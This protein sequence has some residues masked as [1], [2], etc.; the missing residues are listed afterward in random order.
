MK[1]LGL[2]LVLMLLAISA[3]ACKPQGDQG[4][5]QSGP[6][7]WVDAPLPGNVAL[8]QIEI[9]SHA[10]DPL[11]IVQVELSVNG[12]ILRTDPNSDSERT[13]ATMRQK[14]QPPG[15]GNYTLMVRAMNSAN[16]WGD[17]AQ[18]AVTVGAAPT[19]T[20]AQPA[21]PSPTP[22]FTPTLVK[23]VTITPLP[24]AGIAFTADQ[25]SLTAGQCTT[26]RWQVTNA[27]QVLLDNASVAASG[28]KQDCPTRTTTH[29]LR[30]VTLDKQTV[31]RS[32][33]ITVV[34]LTS[35]P[36][37]TPTRTSTPTAAAPAGCSGSPNI[38]GSLSA[39]PATISPG[40]SSTL[41]W[42][43]VTNADSVEIDPDI[44]GVA[45]PGATS[46]SPRQT[47]TY[48]LT[49]RCGSN[50]R[51]QQATVTVTRGII[52]VA[53][54]LPFSLYKSPTPIRPIVK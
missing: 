4:S 9:V 23:D 24:A 1:R 40:N 10:A 29:A 6:R 51:T 22:T 18:V 15:P 44:G 27:S 33:T 52:I 39:S 3:V 8:G 35:T 47:T 54:T 2:I 30:V 50:T 48:T 19:A 41:S 13:L 11:R 31:Q 43:A 5:T 36:T 12:A 20:L 26:I 46:V 28:S 32:L 38:A 45:S 42:G 49:A 37:R 17:Y 14:W 53:P 25:V 21:L 7:S 34:T 16:Q